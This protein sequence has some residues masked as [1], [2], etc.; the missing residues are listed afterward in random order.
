MPKN[1][2]VTVKN[3]TSH[4]QSTEFASAGENV[5]VTFKD[6]EIRNFSIGDILCDP[7]NPLIPCRKFTAQIVTFAELTKPIFNG[8]IVEFYQNAVSL[9]ATIRKIK[10]I[11][12][13]N[14][15]IKSENPRSFLIFLFFHLLLLVSFDYHLNINFIFS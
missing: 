12:E 8:Q 4:E 7:E 1:L 3:I 15:D 2:I 11:L 9:P 13:R 5:D 6:V 10:A 14:G